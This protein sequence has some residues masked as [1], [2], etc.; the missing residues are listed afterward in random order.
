MD[1]ASTS[2]FC[3]HYNCICNCGSSNFHFIYSQTNIDIARMTEILFYYECFKVYMAIRSI[4]SFCISIH[5]YSFYGSFFSTQLTLFVT[6]VLA[7]EQM[8]F[9]NNMLLLQSNDIQV[10]HFFCWSFLIN[11]IFFNEVVLSTL[12]TATL[13]SFFYCFDS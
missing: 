7:L 11:R 13:D 5:L 3:N 6:A 8:N 1:K 12:F 4:C 9:S 10:S 2:N